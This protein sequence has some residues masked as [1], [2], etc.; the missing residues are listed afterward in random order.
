[1]KRC[2]TK[3]T[4]FIKAKT[5]INDKVYAVRR[6]LAYLETIVRFRKENDIRRQWSP[7][8]RLPYKT[9]L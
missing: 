4:H 5:H 3:I 8:N 2:A 1:M 6:T 7:K 9:K